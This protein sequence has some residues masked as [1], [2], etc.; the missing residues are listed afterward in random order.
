MAFAE[1]LPN[2]QNV[3]VTVDSTQSSF[4]GVDEASVSQDNGYGFLHNEVEQDGSGLLEPSNGELKPNVYLNEFIHDGVEQNI[5]DIFN[6]YGY[7]VLSDADYV[8]GFISTI[9]DIDY[10]KFCLDDEGPDYAVQSCID[11]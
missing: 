11:A 9:Q 1:N 8:N 10:F 5:N 2:K 6:Y 4:H 7:D 3:Q